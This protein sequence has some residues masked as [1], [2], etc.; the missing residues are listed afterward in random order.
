[1][2]AKWVVVAVLVAVSSS[3]LR[4]ADP[5]NLR[6]PTAE[7]GYIA[8]HERCLKAR[9]AALDTLGLFAADPKAA[10]AAV[11]AIMPVLHCNCPKCAAANVHYDGK[12][13]TSIAP[14]HIS[15][16]VPAS[17]EPPQPLMALVPHGRATASQ[18]A[19]APKSNQSQGASTPADSKLD[20][21]KAPE[22]VHLVLH[23]QVLTNRGK[24]DVQLAAIQLPPVPK[25]PP[26]PSSATGPAAPSA[27]API[28][29]EDPVPPSATATIGYG[30]S[31]PGLS[32]EECQIYDHA[33]QALSN[34]GAAAVPALP[35]I[36]CL[37]GLDPFLDADIDSAVLAIEQAR[38]KLDNP[39]PAD[40]PPAPPANPP[41][42]PTQ[43]VYVNGTTTITVTPVPA[44]ISLVIVP[45]PGAA[46]GTPPVQYTVTI[47]PIP[48]KSGG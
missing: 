36:I 46:A 1:M 6:I 27:G 39:P 2:R 24:D 32:P 31:R 15:T 7:L 9:L 33:I 37:K 20:F 40:K 47:A 38:A 18:A 42:P 17:H 35:L 26:P 11:R 8:S 19:S 23:R 3:L 34:A 21:L 22:L 30:C 28:P 48:A 10:V 14:T 29:V 4:A 16:L 45:Q 13:Q 12:R 44:P 41:A 5:T 43:Y 25:D